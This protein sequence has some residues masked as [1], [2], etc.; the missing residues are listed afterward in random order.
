VAGRSRAFALFVF[1]QLPAAS[2]EKRET[3]KNAK[4]VFF[5]RGVFLFFSLFL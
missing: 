5:V 2:A 1:C 3:P 4:K